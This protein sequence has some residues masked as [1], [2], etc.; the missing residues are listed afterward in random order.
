MS[1]LSRFDAAIP[2]HDESAEQA[3][4]GAILTDPKRLDDVAAIVGPDDFY[5]ED[6]RAIFRAMLD[7]DQRGVPVD[8]TTTVG[9]LP[10]RQDHEALV[11]AVYSL[12]NGAGAASHAEHYAKQIREKAELR[13]LAAVGIELAEGV[14]IGSKTAKDLCEIAERDL[15][16]LGAIRSNAGPVKMLDAVGDVLQAIYDRREGKVQPGLP[17]GLESFDRLCGG[18]HDGHLILLGARPSVGKSALSLQLAANVARLGHCTLFVSLEMERAEL[19]HRLLAADAGIDSVALQSPTTANPSNA[20]MDR[21]A[22]ASNAIGTLPLLID[23][24]PGQSVYDIRRTARR[25]KGLRFLVVDYL[26][27]VRPSSRRIQRYEQIQEIAGDLKAL[28]KELAVPILVP[29]QLNR[30]ATEDERP[31][32]HHLREGGEQDADVVLALGHAKSTNGQPIDTTLEILKNRHGPLG[33]LDLRFH[34]R[35]VHFEEVGAHEEPRST[36]RRSASRRPAER[37]P[38]FSE[39]E[40]YAGATEEGF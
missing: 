26:G 5:R 14:R 37:Q 22:E 2:P 6:H 16:G 12:L 40:Q 11:N 32:L 13:R 19:V 25:V 17:T 34:P 15:A 38:A 8:A 35:T 39:F 29:A 24:R 23:D 21:L 1:D 4:L 9:A 31:R 7:L 33:I 28:A 10:D 30:S 18:L 3:V 27:L 36:S 20:D